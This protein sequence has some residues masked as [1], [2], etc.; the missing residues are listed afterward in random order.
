MERPFEVLTAI[1]R[2]F[3]DAALCRSV[4][5]TDVSEEH[6]VFVFRVEQSKKNSLLGLPL[7][8]DGSDTV[9]RNVSNF[10]PV[11]VS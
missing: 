9:L 2:F 3:W 4:N 10:L 7:P 11:D 6:N 1:R 8:G 5:I